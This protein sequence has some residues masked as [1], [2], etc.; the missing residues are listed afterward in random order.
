MKADGLRYEPGLALKCVSM[1]LPFVTRG[2]FCKASASGPLG[3][4]SSWQ[5]E[6][7]RLRTCLMLVDFALGASHFAASKLHL[8]IL[9]G[10]YSGVNMDEG[11]AH[12]YNGISA[13][14]KL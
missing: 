3:N 4:E 5:I 6:A 2:G 8:R 1:F 10:R 13:V 9:R 11:N 14:A 7:L 12:H